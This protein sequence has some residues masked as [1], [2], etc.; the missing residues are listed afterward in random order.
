V[1]TSRSITIIITIRI[2][3]S[4]VTPAAK[5]VIGS[6]TRNIAEMPRMAIE[7]PPTSSGVKVLAVR[8]AIGQAAARA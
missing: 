7:E 1:G 8:A 6:I 5:E 2:T 3:T 4:T